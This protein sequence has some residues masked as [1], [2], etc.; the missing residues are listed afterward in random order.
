MPLR[1]DPL[2]DEERLSVHIP[3][4]EAPWRPDTDQ[5]VSALVNAEGRVITVPARDG[6]ATIR[7]AY[8]FSGKSLRVSIAEEL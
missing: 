5:S 6:A 8:L 3:Q 1:L 4:E 7:V 2:C